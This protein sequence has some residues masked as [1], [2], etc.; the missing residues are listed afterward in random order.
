MRVAIYAR[1]STDKQSTDSRA[2]A[3]RDRSPA[4]SRWDIDRRGAATSLVEAS[5]LEMSD[6]F[7]GDA[8]A[9]RTAFRALLGE[10]RM[11]VLADPAHDHC[12]RVEGS[13]SSR[14]PK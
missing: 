5:V 14:S 12:F 6:A 3:S 1:M 11:Q 4:G 10:R 9:R 7:A 13:S 8:D 2:G